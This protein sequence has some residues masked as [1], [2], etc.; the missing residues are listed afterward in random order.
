[1]Q[2]FEPGAIDKKQIRV[3]KRTLTWGAMGIE[4]EADQRHAVALI[5]K[6]LT[7][8]D[9]PVSTPGEDM[10]ED[11][12]EHELETREE[13]RSYRGH[14]HSARQTLELGSTRLAIQREGDIASHV[15]A[16]NEGPTQSR[17]NGEVSDPRN[18]RIKQEIKFGSLDDTLTVHQTQT[19]QA[20]HPAG[21]AHPGESCPRTRE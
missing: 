11:F 4:H 6:N 17:E 13:I 2:S 14:T 16:H 8:K 1:M 19:G 3:L 21:K 15:E 18:S 5:D 12:S 10:N 20:A 9:R 7:S